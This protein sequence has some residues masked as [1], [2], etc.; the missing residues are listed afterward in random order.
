M[1][2]Y[3]AML[4]ALSIAG[5]AGSRNPSFV[6]DY[7]AGRFAAAQRDATAAA[8][9]ST[10]AAREEAALIA[11]LAAHA[12][13]DSRSASQW[14]MPLVSSRD[15]AISGR[16]GAAL[17]LILHEQGDEE[18][19]AS[20]LSEAA[21]KLTGEDAAQAAFH[22]GESF[23]ALDRPDLARQQYQAAFALTKTDHLRR[24]LTERLNNQR[25]T[26]QLGAF[27]NRRNADRA[28]REYAA[29]TSGLGIGAP[30]VLPTTQR[31]RRLFL[32]QVGEFHSQAEADEARQRLGV[33]ALVAVTSND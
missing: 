6:R 13:D 31:G 18:R 25:Y 24:A 5:C 2:A 3:A 1:L 21:L 29:V 27:S 16:A 7:N 26:I 9:V 10:G 23:N 15:R 28:A 8:S 12:L 32:V 30:R 14:L 11:G 33:T 22:A 17:G 4:I 20:L 19:A